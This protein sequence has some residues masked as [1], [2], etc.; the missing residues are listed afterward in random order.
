MGRQQLLFERAAE[1]VLASITHGCGGARL[2]RSYERMPAEPPLYAVCV[3]ADRL[4]EA[5]R[6]R[7][8]GR[9]QLEYHRF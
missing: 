1:Y 5:M 3:T 8:E 6:F 4:E 7:R 9:R 2:G